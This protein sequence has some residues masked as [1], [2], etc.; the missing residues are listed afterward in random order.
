MLLFFYKAVEILVCM[1]ITVTYH[2]Q[3]NVRT[4]VTY[5]LETVLHVHLDGMGRHVL[6]V[7]QLNTLSL[8]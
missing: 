3:S 6:Q 4:C 2:A 7:C 8:I 1:A 5:N